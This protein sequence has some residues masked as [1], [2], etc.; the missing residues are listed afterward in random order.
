[1][2]QLRPARFVD[3]PALVDM[4]VDQQKTSIYAETVNVDRDHARKLLAHMVQRHGGTHD[5][6]TCVFVCEASDGAIAGF[7]AGMLNRVYMIGTELMAQDAFLVVARGA[8]GAAVLQLLDAYLAWAEASPK[9]RE[10][11]LSHTAAIPGSERIAKLYRRKG[12]VPFGRSYRREVAA[13]V[14]MKEAA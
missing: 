4:L 13:P 12:F 7:C 14:T 2:T 3:V 6:A 8:P 11:Q 1:M 10:I 9:V 5:G